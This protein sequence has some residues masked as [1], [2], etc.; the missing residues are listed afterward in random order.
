MPRLQ[1]VFWTTHHVHAQRT[2]GQQDATA[3]GATVGRRGQTGLA[4]L[5][6]DRRL[7]RVEPGCAG[8]GW[9]G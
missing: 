5:G 3:R 6:P 9:G 2:A 1:R 8:L 7:S 4:G